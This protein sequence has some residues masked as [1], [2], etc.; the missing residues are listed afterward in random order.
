ME[1]VGANFFMECPC[2]INDAGICGNII[3]I[4]WWA[5]WQGGNNRRHWS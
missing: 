1:T 3:G 4:A 5:V 2:R